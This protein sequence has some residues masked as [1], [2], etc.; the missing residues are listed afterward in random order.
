MLTKL[1]QEFS[2][3][4]GINSI[5][6]IPE[7]NVLKIGDVIAGQIYEFEVYD[8][9][10]CIDLDI[11]SYKTSFSE[12][13]RAVD[14]F[15]YNLKFYISKDTLT[16]R[17]AISKLSSLNYL[18]IVT[19]NNLE[20]RLIGDTE[21][22]VLFVTK[23]VKDKITGLNAY[24]ISVSWQSV[25]RA[26]FIVDELV[27]DDGTISNNLII[28]LNEIVQI[29]QENINNGYIYICQD[30]EIENPEPVNVSVYHNGLKEYE[31]KFYS[32]EGNKIVFKEPNR[33]L[34]VGLELEINYSL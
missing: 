32:I 33:D 14:H 24:E 9:S 12:V 15:D 19:D 31:S 18:L 22:K 23:L 34:H 17:N 16:L 4:S 3:L 11:V 28:M 26:A 25:F 20:K 27:G 8:L 2:N 21:S 6:L 30:N 10:E 29:S 5:Q 1:S 7:F 13:Q